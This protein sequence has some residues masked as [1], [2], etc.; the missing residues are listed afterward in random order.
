[1]GLYRRTTEQWVEVIA[2]QEL[3]AITS[4]A[5]L[6]DGFANDDVSSIPKLSKAVLHDQSLSSCLLKVANSIQHMSHN[7]VTTVSRAC[8]VLGIQS[9]KN[10]CLTSK[11]IEGMLNNE[12]LSPDI[13]EKLTRQ[14]ASAFF[15][16][17]VNRY[18]NYSVQLL[19]LH[20][21]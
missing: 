15:S 10:I 16:G 2:D 7:K 1:M 14:M 6:L 4:I 20:N 9:V 3:P 18:N 17:R 13:Y 5:R 11:L 19:I 8:V 12:A 21:G